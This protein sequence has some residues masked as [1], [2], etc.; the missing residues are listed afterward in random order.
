[1]LSKER[2]NRRP[3]LTD[4]D[5]K[6]I[7]A[8]V[9]KECG[10]LIP[11]DDPLFDLVVVN[12]CVLRRTVEN[13]CDRLTSSLVRELERMLS[14]HLDHVGEELSRAVEARVRGFVDLYGVA[15][16]RLDRRA[17]LW[18]LGIAAIGIL[19]M[20]LASGLVGWPFQ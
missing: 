18:L 1:M 3:L 12:E 10:R 11:Q 15:E 16:T 9:A 2:R 8:Q 17:Q 6:E 20:A 14:A 19:I 5:K 7:A 13:L 4:E